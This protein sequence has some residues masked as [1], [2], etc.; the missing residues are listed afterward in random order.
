M[1]YGVVPTGFSKKPLEA[2]KESIRQRQATNPLLGPTF[3]N[4]DNTAAGQF[5]GTTASEIAEAWEALEEVYHSYDPDAAEDAALE[6]V[7]AITGTKKRSASPS[8]VVL[9]L[10]LDPGAVVPAGAI[11]SRTGRDDIRFET[12]EEVENTGGSADDFDVGQ[13]LR[14]P[15][16][17]RLS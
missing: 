14:R 16:R 4:G 1:A 12:S 7:A 9:T 2:V 15:G 11:V 6:N 13:L 5:I 17:L 3:D 8:E 10:T